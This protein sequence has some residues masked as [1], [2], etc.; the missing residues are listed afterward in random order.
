MLFTQ[1]AGGEQ[2]GAHRCEMKRWGLHEVTV[3]KKATFVHERKH[4]V[5]FGG[6]FEIIGVS[7]NAA[8]NA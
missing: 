7:L 6:Q 5:I 3:T 2:R 8:I 1:H 4:S